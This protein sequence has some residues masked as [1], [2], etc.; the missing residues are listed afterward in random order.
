[1]F[2]RTG[3]FL[4]PKHLSL[5]RKF[6]CYYVQWTVENAGSGEVYLRHGS[7]Q[8]LGIA[9]APGNGTLLTVSRYKQAWK[10]V[11]NGNTYM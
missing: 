4:R 1:M 8:Y 3:V 5:Y 9:G 6:I 11:L 2:V 7:D 10:P